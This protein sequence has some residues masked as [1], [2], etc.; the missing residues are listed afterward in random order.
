[1]QAG[2]IFRAGDWLLL[3]CWRVVCTLT[4]GHLAEHLGD[5]VAV[6]RLGRFSGAA[7]IA[8]PL[9][10]QPGRRLKRML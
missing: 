3:G 1:M 8:E 7:E 10:T 5:L 4:Q 2:G 6:G 9:G